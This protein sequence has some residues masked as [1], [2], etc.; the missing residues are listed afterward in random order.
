MTP[1]KAIL[2]NTKQGHNSKGCWKEHY[3]FFFIGDGS[4]VPISSSNQKSFHVLYMFMGVLHAS[5]NYALH[6]M[7]FYFE[8]ILLAC[9]DL[10]RHFSIGCWNFKQ[11]TCGVAM[12][13]HPHD[14]QII[15]LLTENVCSL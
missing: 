14:I 11:H 4:Y 9:R 15:C 12:A 13:S 8:N 1:F 10:G 7:M 6:S 5:E 3:C 2:M